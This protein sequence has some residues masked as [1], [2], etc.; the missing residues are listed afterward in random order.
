VLFA[1]ILYGQSI[2]GAVAIDLAYRNPQ[3]VS[4][5]KASLSP[6]LS[7]SE[8]ADPPHHTQIT[9]LIIENTFMSLPRLIP[10]ALPWL[11]PFSFLCHEKWESYLKVSAPTLL[12][13]SCGKF[14]GN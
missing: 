11:G 14:W 12:V 3:A 5:A 10:T 1:Q 2:G 9:A 7:T 4:Q 8:R 13:W 6:L